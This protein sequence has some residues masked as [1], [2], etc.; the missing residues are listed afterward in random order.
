M[1]GV[2]R[3]TGAA[4]SDST[5]RVAQRT[6]DTMK[7]LTILSA[8][9]LPASLVAGVLGMNFA[10]PVFEDAANFWWVVAAMGVLMAVTLGVARYRDHG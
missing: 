1:S 4:G 6:N 8:V 5:T 9:L 10:L 7:T 2:V 3:T